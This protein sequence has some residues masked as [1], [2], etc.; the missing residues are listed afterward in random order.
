MI[1]WSKIKYFSEAEMACKG[2]NCCGGLALMDEEFMLR[3]D[4]LREAL[5]HP[6]PISSGYRCKVHNQRVSSTGAN[7]PH[8][9]GKAADIAISHQ[10]ARKALTAISM[11][12]NGVGFN[13][14]GSGR[15]IHV[16]LL[17]NGRIWTY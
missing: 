12:F 11:R 15:F 13:Q 9:T 14:K 8:T 6:L 7:G 3:L 4:E 5:G 10:Q 16:D 17:G 1:D 2:E